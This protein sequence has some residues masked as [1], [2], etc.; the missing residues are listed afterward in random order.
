[1]YPRQL[2][3][4]WALGSTDS[5]CLC[6]RGPLEVTTSSPLLE[7]ELTVQVA[8]GCVWRDFDLWQAKPQSFSCHSPPKIGSTSWCAEIQIQ[9]G[10]SPRDLCPLVSLQL[11]PAKG[12]KNCL[13]FFSHRLMAAGV[14]LQGVDPQRY[15]L[16]HQHRAGVRAAR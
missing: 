4:S 10:R 6:W 14:P 15:H 8:Q 9:L 1:M 16:R 13:A 12:Q 5:P 2:V 3:F 11:L 7:A